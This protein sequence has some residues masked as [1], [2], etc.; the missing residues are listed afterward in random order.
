MSEIGN[1][2]SNLRLMPHFQRREMAVKLATKMAA[3][4]GDDDEEGLGD[5]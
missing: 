4:L 2:R 1:V 3:M 5:M